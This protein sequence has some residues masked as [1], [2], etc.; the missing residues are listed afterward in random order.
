[1]KKQSIE[2]KTAYLHEAIKKWKSNDA[3]AAGIALSRLIN[4]CNGTQLQKLSAEVERELEMPLAELAAEAHFVA[5]QRAS[6]GRAIRLYYVTSYELPFLIHRLSDAFD[7]AMQES[8]Q[9]KRTTAK[10]SASQPA[11]ET[12]PEWPQHLRMDRPAGCFE[13]AAR[14]GRRAGSPDSVCHQFAH[15]ADTA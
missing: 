4:N 2:D 8:I 14:R 9:P 15:R 12:K 7:A 5:A 10:V 13:C 3:L 11:T 6:K 1:M